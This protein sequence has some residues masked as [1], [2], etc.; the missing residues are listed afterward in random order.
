MSNQIEG[1]PLRGAEELAE[2]IMRNYSGKV[3][4]VGVG[5]VCDV[6]IRLNGPLEVIVTDKSDFHPAGLKAVND[7]IFSPRKEL[8]AGA[9]LLYS[10]RPPLEMQIAMGDLAQEIGADIIVRP[11][12]NEIADLPGFGRTL[13]NSGEARF[14]IFRKL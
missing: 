14:Y 1:P 6:A 8:Y 5:R 9:S 10:I 7:D 3:V 12:E 2:F 13:M 4:E 11:L